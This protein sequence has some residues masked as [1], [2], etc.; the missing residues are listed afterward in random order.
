MSG[1]RHWKYAISYLWGGNSSERIKYWTEIETLINGSPSPVKNQKPTNSE[2]ANL[3][4][5]FQ[6][7]DIKKIIFGN[8]KLT[9]EFNN[10]QTN[11]VETI[12]DNQE[13]STIK[14]Y[15]QEHNKKE[16]TSQEL[17]ITSTS[18]NNSTPNN[19]NHQLLIGLVL[20]GGIVVLVGMLVHFA[21]KRKSR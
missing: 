9:I 3:K 7:L 5:I 21:R 15:C 6:K 12:T 18:S 20:G 11:S 10:H 13:Y 14:K 16:L 1:E 17:N 8:G 19:N 2:L 4:I